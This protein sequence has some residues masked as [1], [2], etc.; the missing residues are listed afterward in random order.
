MGTYDRCVK[1]R[2]KILNRLYKNEKISG[3]FRGRNFLTHTV[4]C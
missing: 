3:P 1:N 4:Y 2:L